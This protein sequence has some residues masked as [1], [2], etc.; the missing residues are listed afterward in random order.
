M[1]VSPKPKWT[2]DLFGFICCLPSFSAVEQADAGPP[3]QNGAFCRY[4]DAVCCDK[5]LY[6][7][8][9]LE[10]NGKEL[11]FFSIDAYRV[12]FSKQFLACF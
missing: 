6:S 8:N 2:E 10:V 12:Q 11:S 7:V 5:A 3:A 4:A 9:C 1:F